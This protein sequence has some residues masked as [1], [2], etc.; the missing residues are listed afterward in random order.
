[1]LQTG[2][3]PVHGRTVAGEGARAREVETAL[4]HG[5]SA[6]RLG[7]LGVGW[8]LVERT[9][10]GPLGESKTTLAQLDPVYADAQL[11]LYR[12]PDTT[13]KGSHTTHRAIAYA[14]HIL[15]AALLV[16]GLLLAAIS[17]PR[18]TR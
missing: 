2:E 18:P 14:A 13:D 7:E 5:D 12:V 10:P 9:T 16:G 17:R 3:L 15:W 1:V 4:L 6:Q 11:A 8:I